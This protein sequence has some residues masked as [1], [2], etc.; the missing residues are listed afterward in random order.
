MSARP[1]AERVPL[2]CVLIEAPTLR[3]VRVP[4]TPSRRARGSRLDLSP[5]TG[6]TKLSTT[7]RAVGAA[8]YAPA[9]LAYLRVRRLCAR[10]NRR[11]RRHRK[12]S[13]GRIRLP[14]M[15]AA[16]L[17]HA[18]LATIGSCANSNGSEQRAA[19][20][21]SRQL[22]HPQLP[23]N[24]IMFSRRET[25]ARRFYLENLARERQVLPSRPIAPGEPT[26]AAGAPPFRSASLRAIAPAPSTPL[27]AASAAVADAG[28]PLFI[29][30][31]QP[32]PYSGVGSGG[33]SR[34]VGSP[35]S[36]RRRT[37]AAR[38]S[39]TPVEKEPHSVNS[40]CA[41]M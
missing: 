12:I 24:A 21:S 4:L 37:E 19:A 31:R 41:V 14:R 25:D 32:Q 30:R 36:P 40:C 16:E 6:I 2:C 39:A 5:N 10:R 33:G 38:Q 3:R 8:G 17:P 1:S 27:P 9:S 29:S 22:C 7:P 11:C 23:P 18:P 35:V 15:G 13:C 28:G 34:G 26:V 20:G